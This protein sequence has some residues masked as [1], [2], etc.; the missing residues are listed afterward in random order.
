MVFKGPVVWIGK[1]QETGPNWTGWT[2]CNCLKIL[3]E[4]TFKMHLKTLKVVS[5]EQQRMIFPHSWH[6]YLSSDYICH[7]SAFF[8]LLI[9]I[10]AFTESAYCHT[11]HRHLLHSFI[12]QQFSPS[13]TVWVILHC[14]TQITIHTDSVSLSHCSQCCSSFVHYSDPSIMLQCHSNICHTHLTCAFT[15]TTTPLFMNFILFVSCI[16]LQ[17]PSDCHTAVTSVTSQS[18][19]LCFFDFWVFVVVHCTV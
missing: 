14:F 11:C 17:N 3:L 9:V 2:C 7:F 18:H 13:I 12:L 8:I 5:L 19:T 10:I 1:R 4:N 16:G 6:I 15:S